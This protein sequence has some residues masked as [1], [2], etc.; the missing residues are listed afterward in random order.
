MPTT[1]M[2]R[3]TFERR[4]SLDAILNPW[5]WIAIIYA[6]QALGAVMAVHLFGL[7]FIKMASPLVLLFLGFCIAVVFRFYDS[8]SRIGPW[9][10]WV[11]VIIYAV[12]VF[13]LS[14]RSYP[15]VRVFFNTKLF[16]PVEYVTLGIFLSGAWHC[17]LKQKGTLGL[18]LC[19]QTSGIV[20]ALS[21]E[22]HQ[23]FIP[24]RT[25][26]LTDV[27]IDSASVAL[28]LAIFLLARFFYQAKERGQPAKP[29]APE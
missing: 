13:L 20:Y 16:H 4:S 28:G 18:V 27:F 22:F 5:N 14:N 7:S 15:E 10:W 24:H 9:K 1:V 25:S 17:L 3:P 6:M 29:L 12:F 19:V 8:P 2:L 11:P 23:S 21:D 26:T